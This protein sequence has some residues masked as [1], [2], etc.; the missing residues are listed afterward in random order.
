[1]WLFAPS[2]FADDLVNLPNRTLEKVEFYHS[3]P[4][5]GIDDTSPIVTD[6]R[7]AH[8]QTTYKIVIPPAPK[9]SN[10]EVILGSPTASDN[11]PNLITS[12]PLA[13]A[14]FYT[15]NPNHAKANSL[16]QGNTVGQHVIGNLLTPTK[17]TKTPQAQTVR[18]APPS[19]NTPTQ[20]LSY[21]T[22]HTPASSSQQLSTSAKVKGELLKSK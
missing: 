21:G 4:R 22:T 11:S 6:W 7:R 2:A 20:A 19:D 15:I 16:P 8:Q 17:P 3:R 18:P 12:R 13:P 10:Q 5:I 14:C 1:V 9:S